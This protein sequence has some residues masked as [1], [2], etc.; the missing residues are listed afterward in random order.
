MNHEYSIT[1]M[2]CAGCMAKVK[3]LLEQVPGVLEVADIKLE[4]PQA[5]L[6]LEK[7][8]FIENLEE[9]LRSHKYEISTFETDLKPEVNEKQTTF[10]LITY[11]PLILIILF[12]AGVS[13]L[14]QY[15]FNDFSIHKYMRHFMA[16]FFIVFSFFKLLDIKGFADSYCMY[17]LLAEKWKVWAY[18]YPFIELGLGISYLIDFMPWYT[19]LSCLLVLGFSSIGVI[20]SN[21]D[22]RKIQCACLGSVFDLPMSFI[23]ILENTIMM[24][25]AGLMICILSI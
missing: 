25:M 19:N 15:P 24:A 7:T 2:T 8:V 20:K 14:A 22:K 6:V 5:I 13:M 3:Y 16:G 11:K 18:I 4:S 17:D 12:I 21:L 23:T 9:A 10:S 1:G